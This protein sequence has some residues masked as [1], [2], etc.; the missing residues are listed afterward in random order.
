MPCSSGCKES[1]EFRI[2][3]RSAGTNCGSGFRQTLNGLFSVSKPQARWA[4]R[5]EASKDPKL[6][7]MVM[8][9]SQK[10]LPPEIQAIGI[11]F[12]E[13]LGVRPGLEDYK[14]YLWRDLE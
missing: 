14:G 9:D 6:E 13:L 8:T 1:T 10:N 3:I 5:V 4:L 12:Q 2:E 7:G 11:W